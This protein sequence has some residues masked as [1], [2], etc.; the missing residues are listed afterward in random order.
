MKKSADFFISF[1][2]AVKI[3]S[4]SL[5][6]AQQSLCTSPN[7]QQ[8]LEVQNRRWL[9]THRTHYSA[10]LEE[11]RLLQY[12]PTEKTGRIRG[13]LYSSQ[14]GVFHLKM[15]AAAPHSLKRLSLW[16]RLIYV[17]SFS[18]FLSA[19]DPFKRNFS[20]KKE[21]LNWQEV[22]VLWGFVG[23]IEHNRREGVGEDF[24]PFPFQLLFTKCSFS[25]FK[26]LS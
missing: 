11:P 25:D 12:P 4:F 3:P 5:T 10:A 24:L 14:R 26:D 1:S 7:L 19:N 23:N 17:G 9:A 21:V 20:S 22:K 13:C 18:S 2:S 15:A 8:R 16:A 6:Q